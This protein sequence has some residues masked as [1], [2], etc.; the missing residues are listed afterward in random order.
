MDNPPPVQPVDSPAQPPKRKKNPVISIFLGILFGLFWFP[1][2]FAG[3]ALLLSI[4]VLVFDYFKI[5]PQLTNV[6]I[7]GLVGFALILGSILFII[8][9]I[10]TGRRYYARSD[11]AGSA[12]R[13]GIRILFGPCIGLV[14]FLFFL[15]VCYAGYFVAYRT[16]GATL[17][18]CNTGPTG[19]ID[20]AIVRLFELGICVP[21]AAILLAYLAAGVSSWI[22]HRRLEDRSGPVDKN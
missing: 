12:R 2:I 1:A 16:P 7:D 21:S 15:V 9:V 22:A 10:I 4:L 11:E 8:V 5:F 13:A 18:P 19:C 17:F 3:L 20:P 6:E 14:G